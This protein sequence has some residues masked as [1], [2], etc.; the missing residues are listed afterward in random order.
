MGGGAGKSGLSK[1]MKGANVAF[2]HPY[3]SFTVIAEFVKIPDFSL[4]GKTRHLEVGLQQMW[5][6]Q[7]K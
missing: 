6:F 2:L 4:P 3:L 7:L 1:E 5:H